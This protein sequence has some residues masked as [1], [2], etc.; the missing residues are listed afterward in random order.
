M[1]PIEAI[2][3]NAEKEKKMKVIIRMSRT[4]FFAHCD[5]LTGGGR[6]CALRSDILLGWR[7]E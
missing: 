1:C 2:N 3:Q 7:P 4:K 5:A 6:F